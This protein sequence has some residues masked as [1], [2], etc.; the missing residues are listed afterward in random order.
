MKF[1]NGN[2]F[3]ECID[4][5]DKIH[6]QYIVAKSERA[7]VLANS[8]DSAVSGHYGYQKTHDRIISKY[9]WYKQADDIKKY[10]EEC[11]EC[12]KFKSSNKYNKA[13]M[14]PIFAT[15]P[16]QILTSD[17]IG[18]LALSDGKYKHILIISGH[19]T[20]YCEFFP[21]ESTTAQETA[22]CFI[23]FIC[24]HGVP[25]SILTDRGT[26]YQSMLMAEI[27]ELLDIH[28]LR[29]TSYWPQCDGN[30]ERMCQSLQ[31]VLACYV[32]DKKDNWSEYLSL[33]QFAYNSAV[34]S[35][36]K[37]SPFQLWYGRDPRMPLDL[38]THNAKIDLYLSLD[39]YA[40]KLQEQL[41]DA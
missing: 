31:K 3:R 30:S 25:E 19:F 38:L 24:R 6:Y 37:F 20:K 41:A 18:P 15:R 16:S 12:Q 26:N 14:K 29:T 22:K 10:I 40:E 21:L 5:N 9:Y 32:N 11:K 34:H 7:F 4:E 33:L 13:K 39:S 17:V 1:L 2:L 27:Y 36:T 35:T 23:Q 8:H 28:Q